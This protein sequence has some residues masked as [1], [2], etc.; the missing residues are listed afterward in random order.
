MS[1]LYVGDSWAIKGFTPANHNKIGQTFSDDVRMA[2]YWDLPYSC[3]FAG[4]QGNLALL[5]KIIK[6]NP[7]P[8]TPIVWI[9][10]EPGRDYNRIT[11]RPEFEWMEREDMWDIRSELDVK[12]LNEIKNRLSNPVAFVGGLSDVNTELAQQLNLY[13][14]HPS[15]QRWIAEQLNSKWFVKGWGAADIGWRMHRNN[16]T[17]GRTATFAWDEQIKEWCWWEE[18]GYFCHEHPTPRANQEFAEYLKPQLYDWL[19]NVK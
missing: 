4:G 17:P 13:V 7:D 9:Y 5:D 19:K 2:D 14:L 10:T 16:V 15:W 6:L 18:H 11:N 12:I 1:I 3:C 8:T